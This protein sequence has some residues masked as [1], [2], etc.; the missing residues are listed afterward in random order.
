MSPQPKLALAGRWG[1]VEKLRGDAWPTPRTS[2]VEKL[3][4]SS[5]EKK[6][7]KLR[8]S[9]VEK[10]QPKLRLADRWGAVEKLREEAWPK[11]RKSSVEKPRKISVEKQPPKLRKSPVEKQPPKLRLQDR[12]G[13]WQPW[14]EN[15]Q[16]R[17]S[18]IDEQQRKFRT[19]SVEI[20][21]IIEEQQPKFQEQR[22]VQQGKIIEGQQQGEII[23]EQQGKIIKEQQQDKIGKRSIEEEGGKTRTRSAGGS[24]EE[25][26][27]KI[28]EQQQGEIVVSRWKRRARLAEEHV[29]PPP[30]PELPWALVNVAIGKLNVRGLMSPEEYVRRFGVCTREHPYGVTLWQGMAELVVQ[31]PTLHYEPSKMARGWFCCPSPFSKDQAQRGR[32]EDDNFGG[33]FS[34]PAYFHPIERGPNG[35]IIYLRMWCEAI[36]IM[37][38]HGWIVHRS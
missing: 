2:S 28:E 31:S 22:Q 14:T 12:W 37:K 4:K 16:D 23:E 5:V 19:T 26:V 10:Q 1:A 34:Y 13:A 11:P 7:P 21:E 33:N 35:S 9:S 6:P 8:K 15:I 27:G 24:I 32:G 3:R 38:S 17:S 36:L 30:P 18:I 29:V 20:E 25:E